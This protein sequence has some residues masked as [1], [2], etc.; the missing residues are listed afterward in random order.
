MHSYRTHQCSE[1]TATDAGTHV[2]VA[3]WVVNVRV[4][5]K[6]AFMTVRDAS[7]IVQLVTDRPPLV[8][9]CQQLKT[10]WAVSVEGEVALRRTRDINPGQTTGMLEIRITALTLWPTD[11]PPD[12][13]AITPDISNQVETEARR[14]LTSLGFTDVGERMIGRLSRLLPRHDRVFRIRSTQVAEFST[15]GFPRWSRL[16]EFELAFATL[17]DLRS[18]VDALLP[19]LADHLPFSLSHEG[20]MGIPGSSWNDISPSVA[21]TTPE[22]F[23]VVGLPVA[24]HPKLAGHDLPLSLLSEQH[25]IR[26]GS[27]VERLADCILVIANG[28]VVAAGSVRCPATEHLRGAIDALQ[29]TNP[30]M[31]ESI[32]GALQEDVER[33]PHAWLLLDI[34]RL[35]DAT[36][37]E[38]NRGMLAGDAWA[39]AS[40]DLALL[41]RTA[42]TAQDMAHP[43]MTERLAN[44]VRRIE[45]WDVESYSAMARSRSPLWSGARPGSANDTLSGLRDLL[46]DFSMSADVCERLFDI[47]PDAKARFLRMPPGER[48]QWL[49]SILGHEPARA[50]LENDSS[51]DIVR[52]AARLRIIN[53]LKQ[54]IYLDI[55]ALNDLSQVLEAY[56]NGR[57]R[58]HAQARGIVPILRQCLAATPTSFT[59]LLAAL[60]DADSPTID[61]ISRSIAAGGSSALVQA[62]EEWL[63]APAL[64]SVALRLAHL[65]ATTGP[66]KDAIRSLG[67][68]I[69]PNVPFHAPDIAQSLIV[70]WS[71]HVADSENLLTAVDPSDIAAAVLHHLFRPVSL[72][73]RQVQNAL[74]TVQDCTGHVDQSGLHPDGPH[75][76]PRG[77]CYQF[78]QLGI[79]AHKLCLYLSKNCP[80]FLAKG[81]VGICTARDLDLYYRPDHHHLNIVDVDSGLVVGNVQLHVLDN[82]GS[83]LLLIRAVN[84]TNAYLDRGSARA[85]VEATIHACLELAASSGIDEVHLCEGVSFWHL[86][87]S[88]PQIR[89][90]LEPFYQELPCVVLDRPFFLYHFGHIPVEITKTYRLWAPQRTGIRAFR[91]RSLLEVVM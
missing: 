84:A 58:D 33:A 2:R 53:D 34:D 47:I 86:N 45:R 66:L 19:R 10:G 37:P 5:G 3:G 71:K 89:A 31:W 25:P 26:S 80:S 49:W 56:S 7:G 8:R 21:G 6:L 75:W 42:D 68:Q 11:S 43:A 60:A 17:D 30:L 82:D 40:H 38:R 62:A 63:C 22:V 36:L 50:A 44:D 51:Y 15:E 73:F 35:V 1:L 70:R 41:L 85:I 57:A 79:A 52:H 29:V 74:S 9:T 28:R 77:D 72:T 39:V 48:F 83:Q 32:S 24:G 54:L 13:N 18:V 69:F 88:R 16:L 64:L 23:C 90:V 4:L 59:A 87:S 67:P 20:V 27:N 12:W 55:P 61:T 46:D 81:S 14:Q 76:F 91:L 65:G 78:P